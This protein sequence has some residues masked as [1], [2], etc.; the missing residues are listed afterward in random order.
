[1]PFSSTIY[2]ILNCYAMSTA[3]GVL[4]LCFL[5]CIF[6]PGDGACFVPPFVSIFRETVQNKAIIFLQSTIDF[7]V[8]V[9]VIYL[10]YYDVDDISTTI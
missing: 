5:L 3:R 2:R 9:V 4:S 7:N 1:M 6:S 10:F 8:I